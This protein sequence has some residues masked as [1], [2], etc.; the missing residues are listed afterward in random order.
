MKAPKRY[1]LP[2]RN[3]KTHAEHRREVFW[4]ISV[5]LVVGI[6]LLL[7]AVGA[8]I[9]SATQSVFE[10]DRWADVSLLWLI[11]PSLFF[12]LIILII[13]IGFIYAITLLLRVTPRYTYIVQQYFEI[14]KGKVSQIS[15]RII[16]PIIKARSS[17]AVVR[18]VG[19]LG[20]RPAD[21][22]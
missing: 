6:L 11:M 13:L 7:A 5:P 12:A 22:Q 19:K 21:E 16:E 9:F 2:K 1:F 3:P 4:Q 18:R 8:I 10:L 15:N 17:W 20:S 14:G